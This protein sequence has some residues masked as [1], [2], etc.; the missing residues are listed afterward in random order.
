M[1]TTAKAA[2]LK[3]LI[4]GVITELMVKTKVENVYVDDS[5][6]LAAKL[7][8]II[9]S[10]NSKATTDELTSGLNG[11]ANATHDHAQGDVTGLEDALNSRPTTSAMN[12]AISA[13]I[14]ELIG[15]APETYNTLKEI[16]DYIAS[17]EDVVTAL[18][19]AIGN[20]ADKSTVTAIQ[21]TVD[22]LGSLA[23]KSAVSESDLDAAL[24]EKVN[25]ASEGNHSHSNKTVLDGI[26]AE[27]V[28]AWNGKGK[29]YYS[30]SQPSGLTAND[31]WVQIVE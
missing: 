26:T 15:G 28:T 8:E 9:T 18:N 27:N 29:V 2:I 17:H 16:S 24:Q 22:A 6:T 12:T 4:E 5:T 19:A 10:L 11:K 31:L 7:S 14:D 3:A 20:K 30:A 25:A 1:A 13:A 23:S 21:T